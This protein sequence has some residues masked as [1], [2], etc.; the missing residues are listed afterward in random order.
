MKPE[1]PDGIRGEFKPIRTN[2]PGYTVCELM[3]LLSQQIHRLSI[4]RG[5]NHHI[6]DHNP[7]SMFM[8][9]SGNA[10]SQSMKFPSWPAVV[11][12]EMPAVPGLPTAVAI[13]SEPSEGP[14][15]GFLGSAYQS[16][17]LQ[18]DPNDRSF[19]VRAMTLPPGIDRARFDRRH[20][21]LNE[22]ERSFERLAE[23]PDLLTSIDQNYRDAHQMILSPR[24]NAAFQI[25][26]EADRLRDRYGRT[27]LGQRCLLARRLIEAG[28]RFVTIS[29]PVGWDTHADNFNALRSNLPVVDHAVS[30]LLEDLAQRGMLQD[31]LVMMFGEFGRTP[32]IN[33]Q[34]GRDHWA[35]AMSIMLAGGGAPA[36][37]IYGSTDRNGA[38]VTDRSHS[39][40]DFACTIYSMLGINPHK[41]YPTPAGQEV[42]IV[43]GGAAIPGLL[44]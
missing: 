42:P 23:R 12:K 17:A 35:Q 15:A 28:V 25:D 18:S 44:V 29:E 4:V 1:A 20:A 34:A 39:P 14:G 26:Q 22:S 24:T 32:R 11:K 3:P 5:V 9:G 6:P 21:L 41:R 8:L 40:A 30:A 43:L 33:V 16:F 13:P 36:G 31:T 27:K 37:L 2:L 7:A 19:Q 38:F 10:P